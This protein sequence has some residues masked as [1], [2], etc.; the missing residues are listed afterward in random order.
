MSERTSAAPVVAP[1]PSL[2]GHH[3]M[4]T[5]AELGSKASANIKNAKAF[6]DKC[7]AGIADDD[8]LKIPAFPQPRKPRKVRVR[9]TL[10]VFDSM[11]H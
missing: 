8:K 2:T 3:A 4:L 7:K 9:S 6:V 1:V 11:V 10:F 5:A